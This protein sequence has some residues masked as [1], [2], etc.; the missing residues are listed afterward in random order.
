MFGEQQH[1]MGSLPEVRRRRAS[2]RE[3]SSLGDEFL[4][5]IRVI[6]WRWSRHVTAL[7]GEESL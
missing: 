5:E 4:R 3:S 2:N 1:Q 7:L 6:A